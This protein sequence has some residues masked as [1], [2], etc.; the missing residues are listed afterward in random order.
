M[1]QLLRC[2]LKGQHDPKRQALGGFRCELCGTPGESLDEM[3]Y[4][5]NGYVSPLRKLYS[6]EKKTLTRT[7]SW[8]D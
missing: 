8:K 5:G 4:E 3:G 7:T 6:R 2:A 1:L